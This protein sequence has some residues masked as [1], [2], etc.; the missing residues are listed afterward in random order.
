MRCKSEVS[1]GPV[2]ADW[3]QRGSVG[4]LFA[5]VQHYFLL[6][7][8]EEKKS[9]INIYKEDGMKLNSPN[10]TQQNLLTLCT[11]STQTVQ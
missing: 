8:T 2:K 10:K 1:L 5:Q 4:A 3:S 7:T 9:L 6:G 11:Q